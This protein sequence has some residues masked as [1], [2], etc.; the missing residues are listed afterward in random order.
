MTVR[1]RR[2]AA[3]SPATPHTHL[4]GKARHRADTVK[5]RMLA[6]DALVEV[7]CEQIG[8]ARSY[9]AQSPSTRGPT[10]RNQLLRVMDR[11]R[12]QQQIVDQRKDRG[13]RTNSQCKRQ[14]R[15]QRKS[16]RLQ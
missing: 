12:L 1:L 5:W 3:L 7:I 13:V 8:R 15:D 16:R 4:R 2:R 14:N 10:E 6:L 9:G 11:Q